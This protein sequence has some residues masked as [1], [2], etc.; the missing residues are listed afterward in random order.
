MNKPNYLFALLLSFLFFSCQPNDTVSQDQSNTGTEQ[1]SSIAVSIDVDEWSEKMQENPG[2]IVDVRTPGEY[3]E[4][5]VPNANLVNVSSSDFM[6]NM[7]ALA[8]NKEAPIYVYCRSGN[9][10]KKAMNMLKNNGF[11]QIY[12]LNSGI[13][14]WQKAGKPVNK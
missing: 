9:R 13:I 1:V 5:Y 8:L 4:G 10:S 6:I 3:A 14:G 2:A 7:D 11:T 12:E